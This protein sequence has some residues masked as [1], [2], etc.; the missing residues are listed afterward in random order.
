[1]EQNL[2]SSK[3]YTTIPQSFSVHKNT[4]EIR[5]SGYSAKQN[6]SF[7]NISFSRS[8]QS[9][10]AAEKKVWLMPVPKE[11][12]FSFLTSGPC[13]HNFVSDLC[14]DSLPF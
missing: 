6:L 13:S 7:Q 12:L 4:E 9:F 5:M 3:Y 8:H 2:F 10:I 14:M 11:F 1:M